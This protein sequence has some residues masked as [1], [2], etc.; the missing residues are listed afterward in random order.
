MHFRV[1]V[2]VEEAREDQKGKRI[3]TTREDKYA[4]KEDEDRRVELLSKL[5]KRVESHSTSQSPFHSLKLP[6]VIGST[7]LY[8]VLVWSQRP[9]F[10]CS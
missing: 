10:D 7:G 5:K 2:E 1:K 9:D 8:A 6:D 3:A 4:E